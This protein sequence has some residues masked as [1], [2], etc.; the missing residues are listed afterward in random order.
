MSKAKIKKLVKKIQSERERVL[1][2]FDAKKMNVVCSTTFNKNK[3]IISREHLSNLI[4]LV[5]K[6]DEFYAYCNK[7]LKLLR[8][9]D[10]DAKA[11][12]EQ[13]VTNTQYDSRKKLIKIVEH[14]ILSAMRQKS[15]KQVKSSKK[16]K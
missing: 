4:K 15:K 7:T 14:I 13:R 16:S 8:T 3:L 11:K 9:L 1:Y 12:K 6:K 2:T 5:N 10:C